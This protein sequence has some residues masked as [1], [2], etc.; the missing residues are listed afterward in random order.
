MAAQLPM[1]QRAHASSI[2]R[3]RLRAGAERAGLWQLWADIP[4][5]HRGYNF[6]DGVAE[7]HATMDYL[8]K[9]KPH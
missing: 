8:R 9:L 3:N 2:G 7:V 1:R 4:G 6:T 5:L